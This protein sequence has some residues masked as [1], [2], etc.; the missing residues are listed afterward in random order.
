MNNQLVLIDCQNDFCDVN[1]SLSVKGGNVDMYNLAT[2]IRRLGGDIDQIHVSLDSH[3]TVD[4]AHPIF[5]KDKNGNHPEPLKT[6]IT[7]KNIEDG[8][9]TTTNPALAT[10][11]LDY[12]KKIESNG[13]YPLVIW[14]PHTRIGTWGHS[15]YPIVMNELIAWEEKFNILN[16]ILKGMNILT[17][18]Y[19]IIKAEII[20][21]KD[22]ATDINIDF[23]KTLMLANN[24]Y[25]AGEAL[26]HCVANSVRDMVE[27]GIDP[28]KMVL[29]SD[30]TSNVGTFEFLG[31]AFVKELTGKGMRVCKSTEVM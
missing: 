5:W 7:S 21:P 24:I 25:I 13:R 11:A 14:P 16:Y 4:I 29:L 6:V 15:I 12:T 20:D 10:Y 8:T 17:E 26:S 18:H 31:D 27:N 19:S 28:N 3:R 9:W 2:M 1:G 30:C 23:L 22:P